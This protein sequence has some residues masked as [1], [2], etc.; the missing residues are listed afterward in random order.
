MKV[1]EEMKANVIRF[2]LEENLSVKE[3]I[4]LMYSSDK[5][6]QAIYDWLMGE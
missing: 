3:Y 4:D 6:H 1:T 5:F 2:M